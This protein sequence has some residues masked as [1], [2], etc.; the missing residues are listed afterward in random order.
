VT[1]RERR[2]HITFARSQRRGSTVARDLRGAEHVEGDARHGGRS[3][4]WSRRPAA[5][6]VM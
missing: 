2:Q 1:Q 5:R 4:Q 3:Y 6:A